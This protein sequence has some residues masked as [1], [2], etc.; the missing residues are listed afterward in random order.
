MERLELNDIASC[1]LVL[2]RPIAAD[3]YVRNRSTGSFIV[4]DR[5]TNNTVGAGM[6]VDVARREGDRTVMHD[7]SREYSEAEK[8]LNAYIRRFYPEW[9]C[10]RI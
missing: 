3:A 4:I 5:I 6:I 1:R 2:N 9:G 8:E 7:S 10:R